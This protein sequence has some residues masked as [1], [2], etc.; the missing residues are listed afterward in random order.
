MLL[1]DYLNQI[2]TYGRNDLPSKLKLAGIKTSNKRKAEMVGLLSEYL[3]K[4]ENILTI[5][6]NLK[7]FDKEFLEEYIR[8]NG[9]LDYDEKQEIIKKYNRKAPYSIY[10]TEDYFDENSRARL[11]FIKSAIPFEIFNIIKEL[12]KPIEFRFRI[13]K[14]EEVEKDS[15]SIICINESFEKDFMNTAKLANNLKLKTTK[16]N[17]YKL[18]ADLLRCY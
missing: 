10:D 6:N 15:D 4:K 11:F 17:G 8:A 12:V 14:D 7:G 16:E 2:T 1:V 9:R 3:S 18:K 13:I 5:W